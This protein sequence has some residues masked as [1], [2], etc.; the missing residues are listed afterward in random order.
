LQIKYELKKKSLVYDP[1]SNGEIWNQPVYGYNFTFFHPLTLEQGLLH[2]SRVEYS[3]L[4]E[5]KNEKLTD[6]YKFLKRKSGPNAKYIVGLNMTVDFIFENPPVF[7]EKRIPDRTVN[8]TY[9]FFVE[10]DQQENIVGGEW[11]SNRHPIF[12][13][14][15]AEGAQ[16]VGR[17]D[18]LVT[19]F[20]GTV[21]ELKQLT[22]SARKVSKTNT[23]LKAIMKYFVAKSS[24]PEP[25]PVPEYLT[26]IS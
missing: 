12:I 24:E 1:D 11:V 2:E 14:N 17:G 20:D 7:G 9:V 10:L 19:K 5:N 15:P 16:I 13:W 23:V 22:E 8:K 21:E 18:D 6:L 4:L 26:Y 3:V 25:R